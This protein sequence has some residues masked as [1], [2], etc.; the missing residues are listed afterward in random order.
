MA[1]WRGE[2]GISLG[3]KGAVGDCRK[4]VS[5]RMKKKEIRRRYGTGGREEVLHRFFVLPERI[6]DKEV[7]LA[8]QAHQIRDVLRLKVGERVIVL[9]NEGWE[10][11]VELTA[12]GRGEVRGKVVE[13]REATGEPGVRITLYQ[14]LLAREKFELVLQKCTEVGVAGFVPVITERSVVRDSGIKASRL[15]RWRRIIQ[16]AAEQS[17]RGRLPELAAPVKFEDALAGLD[18][19]EVSLIAAPGARKKSLRACLGGGKGA[20]SIAL[21]IGPEGGFTEDEVGQACGNGAVA[22]SLGERIL[23]TETAAVVASS[24][25]LYEMGELEG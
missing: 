1:C 25:I 5:A 7:V 19:F 14:S 13:K 6:R 21:F 16:E 3:T 9:D 22:F 10:Y 18:R 4:Q 11:E 12:V 2:S 20:G 8:E 23:R 17:H 15:G 24:V